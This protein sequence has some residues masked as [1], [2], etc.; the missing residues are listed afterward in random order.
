[1]TFRA[2]YKTYFD[3]R[4]EFLTLLSYCNPIWIFKTDL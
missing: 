2:R 4:A 1:V 3:F